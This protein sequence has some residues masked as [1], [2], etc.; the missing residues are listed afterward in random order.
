MSIATAREWV[1]HE[2]LVAQSDRIARLAWL[3]DN[4]PS[5]ELGFL[6]N[7]GW[8]SQKLLEEAKYCFVYGQFLAAS[9]LGVAFIERVLAAQF[10]ATGRDELE[11]ASAQRLLQEALKS[12]WITQEEFEQF[13]AIRSLRN[14]IVHF[15]KPL[16]P[17]THERRA[18][19]QNADLYE[20]AE[21]DA[22][23]ILISVFQ[24]LQRSNTL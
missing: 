15:R 16:S 23:A 4:Y 6:L 3:V 22:E 14:P 12:K 18:I 19:K 17:D 21:R 9:I 2:D 7:G 10:Y 13:D 24:V 20:I 5:S 1:E 11:R 8:L